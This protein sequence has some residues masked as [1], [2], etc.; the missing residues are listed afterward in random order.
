MDSKELTMVL[1]SL[2]KRIES[3]ER[4]LESLPIPFKLMY[5]P[6]EREDYVNVV[7]FLDETAKR[8]KQIEDGI[9]P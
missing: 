3:I 2:E 6:P 9:C 7:D 5:R 1:N 8:L 4:K